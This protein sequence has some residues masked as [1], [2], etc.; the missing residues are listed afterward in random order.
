MLQVEPAVPAPQPPPPEA[1]VVA[2]GATNPEVKRKAIIAAIVAARVAHVEAEV[3]RQKHA[4]RTV[5]AEDLFGSASDAAKFDKREM[6]DV[7]DKSTRMQ[8]EYGAKK[9]IK[10]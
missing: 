6:G 2:A 10:P 4:P 9:F 1:P 5:T 7:K 8:G 3:A